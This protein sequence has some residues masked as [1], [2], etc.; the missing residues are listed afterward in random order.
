VAVRVWTLAEANEALDWVRECLTQIRAARA[1]RNQT[2]SNG[3]SNAVA[4]LRQAL[5]RLMNEGI[6][7]RDPVRGLIDFPAV[8][9]DGR[10]YWLCWVEGEPEVGFWHWRDEGFPGRKPLST[11]PG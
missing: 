8:A 7:V 9:P 6:V 10:Q 4:P 2:R 5:E 3:Q 11:P 1:S